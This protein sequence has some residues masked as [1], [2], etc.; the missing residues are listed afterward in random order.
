M[1]DFNKNFSSS[2]GKKIFCA[3][4]NFGRNQSG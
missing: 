3:S 2:V 1:T 4:M